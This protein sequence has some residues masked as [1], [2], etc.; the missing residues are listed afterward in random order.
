ME[1]AMTV[2]KRRMAPGAVGFILTPNQLAERMIQ[3]A[4]N[5]HLL[6]REEIAKTKNSNPP[7]LVNAKKYGAWARSV[8]KSP[9]DFLFQNETMDRFDEF[10]ADYAVDR[11]RVKGILG[12]EPAA[13]SV[14]DID[15]HRPGFL[16]MPWWG[17]LLLIGL[18]YLLIR[19]VKR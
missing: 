14:K 18:G 6:A 11:A 17:W 16:N 19:E 9:A 15:R 4:E 5:W 2:K 13:K 7:S 1:N 12:R 10:R 3:L 8:L